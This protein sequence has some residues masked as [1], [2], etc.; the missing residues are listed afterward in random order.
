M[1]LIK[2]RRTDTV[3]SCGVHSMRQI[4]LNHDLLLA[5]SLDVSGSKRIGLNGEDANGEVSIGV[6]ENA[7][8]DLL[9]VWN[10]PS[11]QHCP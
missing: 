9:G 5:P 4:A 11:V 6:S 7:R 8:G 10:P 1:S 2:L 3:I